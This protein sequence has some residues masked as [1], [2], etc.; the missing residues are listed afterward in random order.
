MLS[1][2]EAQSFLDLHYGLGKGLFLLKSTLSPFL[3]R[4]TRAFQRN[5]I[6]PG[7]KIRENV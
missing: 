6:R 7:F 1:K 2:E 3:H 5:D 4:V